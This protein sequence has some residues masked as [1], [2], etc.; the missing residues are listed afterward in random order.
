MCF[1]LRNRKNRKDWIA[2][3]STDMSLSEE[4]IIRIYGK[5]WDI[6]VFFKVTKSFLQLTKGFRGLSYDAMTVHVAIVFTRYMVLA[7]A[8]RG[9][10]DDRMLGE[11]FYLM[12]SEVSD[13]T[14]N[15]ALVLLVEA[16]MSAVQSVLQITDEQVDSIVAKFLD[17]LPDHMQRNLKPHL[18]A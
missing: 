9:N 14:Y 7:V 1:S 4:D 11:L 15:E 5:R 16:M 8:K 17:N 6:E 13:M 18:A 12:V 10:E 3:I 2:L